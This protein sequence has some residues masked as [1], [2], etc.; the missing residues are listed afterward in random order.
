MKDLWT[1]VVNYCIEAIKEA[2]F[3]ND[4]M[5]LP[6]GSNVKPTKDQSSPGKV[7][8]GFRVPQ[9]KPRRLMDRFTKN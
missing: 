8:R 2:G 4:R 3:G 1:R 7:R 5:V 6:K 9:N